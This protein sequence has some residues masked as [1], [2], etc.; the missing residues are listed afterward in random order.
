MLWESRVE[1]PS[2]LHTLYKPPQN[3]YLKAQ[4]EERT[5]ACRVPALPSSSL[6]GEFY[7]ELFSAQG[8]KVSSA[9]PY[10]AQ[11]TAQEKHFIIIIHF[12][13]R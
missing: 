10:T 13:T 4:D 6:L 3:R 11:V 12:D 1:I 2:L 9:F 5:T 7:R 8:T